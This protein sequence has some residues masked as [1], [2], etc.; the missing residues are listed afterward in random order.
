MAESGGISALLHAL[1]GGDGG[2]SGEAEEDD[3]V[4]SLL[5]LLSVAGEATKDADSSPPEDDAPEPFS[6]DEALMAVFPP[7]DMGEAET[8]L[9][10]LRRGT[11]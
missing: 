3:A 5:G 10:E 11:S 2:S 9:A 6:V 8:D 7:V 1:Q 4:A